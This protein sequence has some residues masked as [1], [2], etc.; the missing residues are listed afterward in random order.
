MILGSRRYNDSQK[1]NTEEEETPHVA[2]IGYQ[3]PLI[4]KYT[5]DCGNHFYTYQTPGEVA[6]ATGACGLPHDMSKRSSSFMS[7]HT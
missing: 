3:V 2:L 1:Q 5:D 7:V 6:Y 4:Y